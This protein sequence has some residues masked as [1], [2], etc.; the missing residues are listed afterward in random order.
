VFVT[1]SGL[2]GGRGG[3]DDSGGNEEGEAVHGFSR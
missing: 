3:N 2:G 1:G